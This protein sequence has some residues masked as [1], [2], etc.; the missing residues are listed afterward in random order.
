MRAHLRVHLERTLRQIFK[1][2][3]MR[4]ITGQFSAEFPGVFIRAPK[5]IESKPNVHVLAVTHNQEVVGVWQDNLMATSFH[6]ELTQDCR[7]HQFFVNLI[8]D[9][10]FVR[11]TNDL[12]DCFCVM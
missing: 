11:V 1:T 9:E 12:N 5:I 10:L 7:F 3:Q 8:K 4:N 6:P 2:C